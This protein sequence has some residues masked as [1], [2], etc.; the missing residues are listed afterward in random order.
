ME[1]MQKKQIKLKL[2]ISVTMAVKNDNPKMNK[3]IQRPQNST[4]NNRTT[5]KRRPG[6]KG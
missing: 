4:T 1:L 5:L 6:L 2:R 3:N